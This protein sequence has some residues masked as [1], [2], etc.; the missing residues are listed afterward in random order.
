VPSEVDKAV[1][2]TAVTSIPL[3]GVTDSVLVANSGNARIR[4]LAVLLVAGAT[5]PATIT[6]NSKG[7]G[8]GTAISPALN[9]PASANTPIGGTPY[10][11]FQTNRGESLTWTNPAGTAAAQMVVV[12]A[13]TY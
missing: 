1:N 2:F 10:G 7:S 3:A 6:F 8:A 12:Y 4:V 13:F 5:P 9:I 11:L